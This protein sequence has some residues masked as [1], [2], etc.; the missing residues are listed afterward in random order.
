MDNLIE[1]LTSSNAI[2][3]YITCFVLCM[4][5]FISYY[6]KK[7]SNKRRQ[8]QNTKELENIVANEKEEKIKQLE[9]DISN[10]ETDINEGMELFKDRL[11]AMYVS[12]NDSLA[13]ALVGATDFYD[14]LSKIELISQVAKH[15][16]ELIDSLMTQLQQF[17]EA[18]AQL[19]ID[20]FHN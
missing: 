13:S 19:D 7:N 16:D 14:M 5:V 2:I 15:D 4:G 1:F 20:R 3:I 12:G 8:K 11:R 6:L 17:E 10:K 18:Q 9:I